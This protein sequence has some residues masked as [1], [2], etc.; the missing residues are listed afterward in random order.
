MYDG[1]LGGLQVFYSVVSACFCNQSTDFRMPAERNF[2]NV[3]SS[4]GTWRV[5]R[6]P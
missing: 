2:M 1:V 3:G 4:R 5:H 6:V